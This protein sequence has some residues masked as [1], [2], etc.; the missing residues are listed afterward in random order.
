[1]MMPYHKGPKT[2]QLLHPTT[3]KVNVGGAQ[4]HGDLQM[5]NCSSI[6][7]LYIA[8]RLPRGAVWIRRVC[9]TCVCRATL[10]KR[11][12]TQSSIQSPPAQHS[13]ENVQRAERIVQPSDLCWLRNWV[14]GAS[15]PAPGAAS[16]EAVFAAW[17][18][19]R[20]TLQAR[21]KLGKPMTS[22]LMLLLHK[23]TM[24]ACTECLREC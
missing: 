7:R 16:P 8:P 19:T 21:L 23:N 4:M 24:K 20:Q 5:H 6:L 1:M 17:L 3:E 12:C 14:R 11:S 13:L 10:H 9:A 15:S 2:S 18:R 22:S